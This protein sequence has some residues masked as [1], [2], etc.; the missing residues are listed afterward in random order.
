[1]EE[2]EESISH[3]TRCQP[4]N[5][6]KQTPP[7]SQ[8]AQQT[9]EHKQACTLVHIHTLSLCFTCGRNACRVFLFYLFFFMVALS[10]GNS[11]KFQK[12]IYNNWPKT[13]CTCSHHEQNLSNAKKIR[14]HT[15]QHTKSK[16]NLYLRFP[17]I[18]KSV[19]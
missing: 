5:S 9:N 16:I 10:I 2:K 17:I 14:E 8:L 13:L 18:N 15:V 4:C 3:I 6:H 19:V 1:M 11:M 12:C 7:F